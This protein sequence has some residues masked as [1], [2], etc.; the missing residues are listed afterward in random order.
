MII[1]VKLSNYLGCL[2]DDVGIYCPLGPSCLE[3]QDF[4]P[5][6]SKNSVLDQG[7]GQMG[8]VKTWM[9]T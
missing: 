7:A 4:H 5:K 2:F 6:L 8:G 9:S 3:S 1:L